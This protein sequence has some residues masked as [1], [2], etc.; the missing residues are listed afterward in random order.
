MNGDDDQ[1]IEPTVQIVKRTFLQ[2]T[3]GKV[4]GVAVLLLILSASVFSLNYFNIISPSQLSFLPKS[5]QTNFTS[6]PV[7]V[8]LIPENYGF[9]AGE[10]TLS[11]PLDS[12]FCKSQKL[13]QVKDNTAVAYQ[14]A[15]QSG[16]LNL[17]RV[18]N[19]EN[20]AIL[21]NKKEGKKYFYESIVSKS[22]DSCYTIAYTLPDDASFGN[23]LNLDFLKEN[24]PFAK[25][26]TK[27]IEFN[28]QEVNVVI[29]VRNSPID[30]GIPC[31]LIRKSPEFFKA[32]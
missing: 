29:Q 17:I 11:C 18:S 27:S 4:A 23:I 32:F 19:L 31:S 9:K 13:V 7:H 15:S 30:P 2:T 24:L 1:K 28:G 8:S 10:L 6:S 12:P 20:I 3:K 26:G 16:V 5:S 25:L 22:N 14:A 21:E